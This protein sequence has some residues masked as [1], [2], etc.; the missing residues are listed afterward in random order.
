[1]GINKSVQI[2]RIKS[3]IKLLDVAEFHHPS[4]QDIKSMPIGAKEHFSRCD[5]GNL[6]Q[7]NDGLPKCFIHN[8]IHN[9]SQI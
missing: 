4:C 6:S 8:Q 9:Q 5:P 3:L 2:L 1:M 7:A